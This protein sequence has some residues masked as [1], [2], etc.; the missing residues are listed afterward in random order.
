MMDQ[1]K[2]AE[3][4]FNQGKR[5]EAKYM[6]LSILEQEPN[7]A[8][9]HNNM[10][11]ILFEEGIR[12]RALHHLQQALSINP[13]HK[14]AI[15]NYVNA[16]RPAGQVSKAATLLQRYVETYP[17]D[18]EISAVLE[19]ALISKSG[20]DIKI[21]FVCIKGLES[22]LSEI[23]KDLAAKYEVRTCYTT[24]IKE[25]YE[26]IDWA[27]VVWLEWANES[28]LSLTNHPT[29]LDGKHVICRLHS[30]EAFT[31]LPARIK[32]ERI[33]DL[34]FVGEHI[35]RI[36]LERN[37]SLENS[38][39]IHTIPNGVNL[40]RFP[41]K[42]RKEGKKICYLGS[43]NYKKGPMLLFHAFYELLKIDKGYQLYIGGDIQDL[44][45]LL[46]FNQ[47]SRE[48]DIKENIHF[49]GKVT[50]VPKWFEDKNYIICSSVLESQN[51][52]IMEAMACG[53]KPLIHN[54]AGAR[55]IYPPE[56]VWTTLDEFVRLIREDAYDSSKYREFIEANYSLD[57]QLAA[58][59]GLMATI[60]QKRGPITQQ[61]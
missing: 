1:L 10:G 13:F 18:M 16:L 14:D 30:Y 12:D 2:R 35:R 6:L 40:A 4:L 19:E 22:F 9:A 51:M 46:Y 45:Y 57:K 26:A 48:L 37:P 25:T 20:S 24:N 59:T 28:T 54:F 33:N 47:L 3:E 55:G 32:W 7:N 29:I 34:V 53:I 21:A 11:V 43:I 56:L 60:G 23:V 42:T 38:T 58:I 8:E 61:E 5:R 52:A 36:V 41:H 49:V 50:D 44:R 15:V 39:T 17:D 31:P 27:D